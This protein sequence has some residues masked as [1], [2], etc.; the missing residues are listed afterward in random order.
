MGETYGDLH[1]VLLE[2]S[3]PAKARQAQAVRIAM[4]LNWNQTFTFV[5]LENYEQGKLIWLQG[6]TYTMN[7]SQL[8]DKLKYDLTGFMAYFQPENDSAKALFQAIQEGVEA[9]SE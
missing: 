2:L 1:E 4:E 6:D 7:G 5:C 8:F 3:D 9:V